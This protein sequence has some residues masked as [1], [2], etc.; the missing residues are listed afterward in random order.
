VLGV[1]Y[2][3]AHAAAAIKPSD[4]SALQGLFYAVPD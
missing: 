3:R 1:R 2:S 4:R